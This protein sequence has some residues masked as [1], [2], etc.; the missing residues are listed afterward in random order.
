VKEQT[1]DPSGEEGNESGEDTNFT[2]SA[3]ERYFYREDDEE[4]DEE[5]NSTDE[6]YDPNSFKS[7]FINQEN[8]SGSD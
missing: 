8:D 4:N 6:E 2:H 1:H 7:Y 3:R 5:K